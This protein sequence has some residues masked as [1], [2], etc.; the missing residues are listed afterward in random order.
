MFDADCSMIPVTTRN[1]PR[2]IKQI[3]SITGNTMM[4]IRMVDNVSGLCI[5]L[6]LSLP[7]GGFAFI[8]EIMYK[9]Q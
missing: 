2:A 7:C 6:F 1:T 9:S 3:S 4:A 5:T 8:A